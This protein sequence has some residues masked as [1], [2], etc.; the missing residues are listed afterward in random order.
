MDNATLV[1]LLHAVPEMEL[2][3]FRL[4][5]RHQQPDGSVDFTAVAR[6]EQEL[7]DATGEACAYVQG[8]DR[9]AWRV[10]CLFRAPD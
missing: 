6:H 10:K 2:D 3:I 9:V 8:T 4:L 5:A 7:N 1:Q